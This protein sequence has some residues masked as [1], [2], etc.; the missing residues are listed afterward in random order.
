ME[1]YYLPVLFTEDEQKRYAEWGIKKEKF[2]VPF[3]II[4]IVIDVI[5]VLGTVIFFLGVRRSEPYFSSWMITWSGVI[6]DVVSWLAIV[7]TMLI[8]KPLDLILDKIYKKPEEPKTLCL[9][10]NEKGVEYTLIQS[11]NVIIDGIMTWNEWK[12]SVSFDTNEIYIA[13]EDLRIGTN[14]IETIY[15]K[16]KQHKWMDRPSQ[17]MVTTISLKKISKNF[18][19]YLA[20]LEEKRKEEEWMKQIML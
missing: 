11:G 4:T 2:L 8:L 3:A 15:P 13:G 9:S 19:G 6:G 17:K 18:E 14:T 5:A 7:L 16:E 20:S 1:K 10:P 12:S